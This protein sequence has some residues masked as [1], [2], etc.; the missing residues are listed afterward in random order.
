MVTPSSVEQDPRRRRAEAVFERLSPYPGDGLRN[1]CLRIYR[2]AGLALRAAGLELDDGL[3]YLLAL[4]HDLGLVCDEHGGA[5]YLQR[6]RNLFRH[7]AGDLGL[8]ARE[9][10]LGDACLLLNHRLLPPRDLPPEAAAFRRAVWIEHSRGVARF[11]VDAAEVAAIKR[12]LPRD[13]FDRVLVDFTRRVVLSEPHTL[14][15]GIFF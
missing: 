8:S 5:D 13:N 6:S 3:L 4:L 9:L 2:Y 7:E 11:G 14:V 15:R 10:R 1:H 12:A